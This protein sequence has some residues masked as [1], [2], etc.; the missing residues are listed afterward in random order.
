MKK[1]YKYVSPDG[2]ALPAWT[3]P[4]EP[5]DDYFDDLGL[6]ESG[7]ETCKTPV[8][9]TG[10]EDDATIIL[11]ETHVTEDM[12]PVSDADYAALVHMMRAG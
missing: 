5:D 4:V 12:T 7:D 9:W 8:Y 2:D 3:R 6:C 11:C 10:V 1:L